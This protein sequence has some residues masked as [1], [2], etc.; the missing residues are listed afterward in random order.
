MIETKTFSLSQG[1]PQ[2]D[3]QITDLNKNLTGKNLTG[4]YSQNVLIMPNN[5]LQIHLQL[6][7]KRT[8]QKPAEAT[9]DLTGNKISDKIT[10]FLRTSS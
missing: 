1:N 3:D 4:K 5:L 8:I 2:N 6:L 7:Q 10:K 9:V